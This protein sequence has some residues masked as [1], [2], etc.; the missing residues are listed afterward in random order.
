MRC[1]LFPS[2]LTSLCPM[3]NPSHSHLNFTSLL[4]CTLWHGPAFNG[5]CSLFIWRMAPCESITLLPSGP[6]VPLCLLLWLYVV[7]YMLWSW[8]S[9][10]SSMATTLAGNSL[11]FRVPCDLGTRYVLALKLPVFLVSGRLQPSLES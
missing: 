7:F 3:D 9:M 4:L 2:G 5:V 11:R 8:L 6:L 1:F 10:A